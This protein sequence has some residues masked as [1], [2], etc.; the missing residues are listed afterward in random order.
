MIARLV[1]ATAL[2]FSSVSAHGGESQNACGVAAMTDY[3][4]AKLALL[5]KDRPLMSAE[6]AIAERRL[7]E[8][9]CL[10]LVRCVLNDPNSLQFK[11]GFLTCLRDEA[12]E[13]YDAVG[14]DKN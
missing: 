2:L 14:R 7:E 9:F 13:K 8:D 3:N 5:Q 12:L 1:V 10:R 6:T 11:S 4:R